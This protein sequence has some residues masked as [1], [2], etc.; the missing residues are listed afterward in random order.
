MALDKSEILNFI[1]AAPQ[2][3]SKREIA[4]AFGIKGGEHR[5]ALKQILKALEKEGTIAR[6]PGGDYGVP[7]SLPAVEIVEIREISV[8]GDVW[9]VPA[10]WNEELRGP[11]PRIEIMP[12]K[13]HFPVMRER[14]R[15]LCRLR[16]ISDDL[17][18]AHI[19]RPLD[20][21]H[22]LVMGLVRTRK[23]GSAVLIPS[24]KKAKADFDVNPGDLNGARDGDLA[25][26]EFQPARGAGRKRVRIARV[27]GR[28]D[29]PRA[30]SLISLHENGLR[31]EWP[32][33]AI[34]ETEGLKVPDL[35]GREDLRGVPLVTI[36]GLDARDF[37][38]AVFA[39]RDGN[40]F[41]LIVAIADVSYYVRPGTALDKEARRRGNST[42]FPDRVVPMLPEALSNDLC[43]LR[44]HEPRACL[45]AHL[46]I[47]AQGQLRKYKFGRGLMKSAARL[48][49]EQVQA[50]REGVTDAVTEALLE[51]VI[52]PLY[53]AFGLLDAARRKRGAL[54]LDLPERQILI[55]ADGQMTGVKK[56]VRLDSHKLIEE[57][58]ILANVAAASALEDKDDPKT[59]PC[60][61][62]IHDRPGF[63][64]LESVREFVESLGISLP[65]GQVT[66]PSQING[67][68]QQGSQTPYSHLVSQVILRA[69]A[70]AVYSTRNIGHF[71]LALSRYAHFTSP[72]RRY[73]DLLVHR[74]LVKAYG[75]GPG[76]LEDEEISRMDEICQGISQT[77][78][79][80]MEA[81]RSAVD[82]FTAAW[83]SERVGAEFAGK[84]SGVTRFGLFVTL[85][86]SGADGLIPMRALGD[87]FYEHDERAHALIGRRK[88]KVF[89]LGAAVTVRLAEAD[90]LTGSTLLALSGASR[91]GADIPGFQARL[92]SFN[93][94]SG[95][96]ARRRGGG[97]KARSG[98]EGEKREGKHEKKYGGKPF[99]HG[100]DN[101]KGGYKGPGRN[102]PKRKP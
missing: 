63:D 71:G 27:I 7:E 81:E 91:D 102:K 89:R 24:D 78:R 16:R 87:D 75:L 15:A 72:I 79:V 8:D 80:S 52:T 60:V 45:A 46:W 40:G 66:Q 20:S 53:E 10:D 70:Q 21:A 94:P 68:L 36:D 77:E 73:A 1:R 35:K 84:I 62:R 58:M 95:S 76:G 65:K 5:V 67:V 22:G 12:D 86:E 55:D 97:E 28:Q 100:K 13:K 96:P 57:F 37:D 99:G 74:A 33:A 42:Y 93:F 101:S 14:A 83:L 92:R 47:D 39:E 61:Y 44:P 49:Y 18:E 43:S 98:K 31:E 64:K 6:Q 54:E 26:G 4:H 48:T 17:Y 38:D 41:H 3:V 30:I 29:D 59:L 25:V 88:G 11:R 69:Q 32:P 9:G 23:G 19:I 34:R 85:D 82:R 90:G 50:A 51:P 2:A 56:R